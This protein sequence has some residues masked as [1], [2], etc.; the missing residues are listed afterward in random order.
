MPRVPNETTLRLSI[1]G[2]DWTLIETAL[3]AYDHNAIYRD[4][5][6]RLDMQVAMIRAID[7]A[8]RNAC[9]GQVRG[10]SASSRSATRQSR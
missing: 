1:S 9:S 3:T 5:R 7:G 2:E 4:L 8:T 10:A 6:D